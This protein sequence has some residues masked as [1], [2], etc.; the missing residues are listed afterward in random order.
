MSAARQRAALLRRQLE[1]GAGELHDFDLAPQPIGNE[2]GELFR[3]TWPGSEQ[4]G[5]V[6]QR[7]GTDSEARHQMR[8]RIAGEGEQGFRYL[9]GAGRIGNRFGFG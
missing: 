7:I 8:R 3:R 5:I 4:P 2:S 6:Q 9:S 1:P